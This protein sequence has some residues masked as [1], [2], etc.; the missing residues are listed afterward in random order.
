LDF[1][2]GGGRCAPSAYGIWLAKGFHPFTPEL[3]EDTLI[4]T[5]ERD[6]DAMQNAPDEVCARQPIIAANGIEHRQQDGINANANS[7]RGEE[8]DTIHE[9][10][11]LIF[12]LSVNLREE[13]A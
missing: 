7:H 12:I 5:R 4:V 9:R 10:R 2:L 6:G 11:K 8:S 3:G 1:W 13:E